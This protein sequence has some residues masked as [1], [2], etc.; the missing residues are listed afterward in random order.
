MITSSEVMTSAISGMHEIKG[1]EPLDNFTVAN[2][3]AKLTNLQDT[4]HYGSSEPSFF[5]RTYTHVSSFVVSAWRQVRFFLS[6][7]FYCFDCLKIKESQFEKLE[8]YRNLL[9]D[10][11]TNF[12]DR[13]K[14]Y[15]RGVAVDWWIKEFKGLDYDLKKKLYLQYIIVWAPNGGSDPMQWAIEN[16]QERKSA[17][18]K[19]IGE[20]KSFQDG[21]GAEYDPLD[22]LLDY[23]QSARKLVEL[24]IK[25]IDSNS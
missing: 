21:H 15:E 14:R 23:I 4:I 20:L 19:F 17:A 7:I 25:K 18:E 8:R 12:S 5:K 24:E 6:K 1:D 2:P 10:L 13:K 11:A 16:Y 22:H 9:S 3:F